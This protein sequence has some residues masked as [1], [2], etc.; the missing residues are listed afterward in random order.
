M[1]GCALLA[2]YAVARTAYTISCRKRKKTL[3]SLTEELAEAARESIASAAPAALPAGRRS[4]S[5]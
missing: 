4:L 5:P 1:E 2:S 3:R